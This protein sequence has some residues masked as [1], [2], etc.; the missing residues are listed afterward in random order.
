[1]VIAVLVVV[2]LF[3][4]A[5]GI[6][7]DIGDTVTNTGDENSNTIECVLGSPENGIEEC[8]SSDGSQEE[9]GAPG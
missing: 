9:G 8:S 5:S 7:G 1:M 6:I 3:G 2:A 4:A